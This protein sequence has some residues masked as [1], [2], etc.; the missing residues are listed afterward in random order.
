M[1]F[2]NVNFIYISDYKP[3]AV[4]QK[5]NYSPSGRNTTCSLAIPVQRSKAGVTRATKLLQK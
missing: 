5:C 4:A 3:G 1:E 2:S